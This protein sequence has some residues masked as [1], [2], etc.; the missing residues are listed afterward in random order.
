MCLAWRK[1]TTKSP[2]IVDLHAHVGPRFVQRAGVCGWSIFLPAFE[3]SAELGSWPSTL[4]P[5]KCRHAPYL[6]QI[7]SY[8]G[9]HILPRN[10]S[11][12]RLHAIACQRRRFVAQKAI[13]LCRSSFCTADRET[14]TIIVTCA[15]N[16]A[17]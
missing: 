15:Q 5:T 14:C 13:R 1:L 16:P 11:I 4:H 2:K 3:T 9:L 17:L 8:F 12:N 7:G 10:E 6:I